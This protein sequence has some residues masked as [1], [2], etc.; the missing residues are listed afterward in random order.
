LTEFTSTYTKKDVTPYLV[1]YDSL[2]GYLIISVR[3]EKLC[4]L[5]GCTFWL[6]L[7]VI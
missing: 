5:D 7:S 6:W 2:L 1:T 4:G 3:A